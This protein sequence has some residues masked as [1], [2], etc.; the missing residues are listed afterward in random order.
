M[1]PIRTQKTN[2]AADADAPYPGPDAPKKRLLKPVVKGEKEP[3]FISSV[4]DWDGKYHHLIGTPTRKIYFGYQ[5]VLTE[6]V[7]SSSS[8]KVYCLRD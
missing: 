3:R 1:P 7:I 4:R 8:Q 5:F 6:Y 2:S